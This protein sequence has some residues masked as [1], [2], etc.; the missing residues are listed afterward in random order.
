MVGV[1]SG[2]M[3]VEAGV[4]MVVV[5]VVRM[6]WVMVLVWVLVVVVGRA[7]RRTGAVVCHSTGAG[8]R[9]LPRFLYIQIVL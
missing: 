3:V 6:V 5:M 8:V 9:P 2:V 7:N 1:V 4:A